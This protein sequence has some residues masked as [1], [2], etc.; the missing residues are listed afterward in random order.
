MAAPAQ[1]GRTQ[2][3]VA[4][5][6]RENQLDVDDARSQAIQALAEFSQRRD[7]YEN[8]RRALIN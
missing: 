3:S 4:G 5:S 2:R 8:A 7:S 6:S 1:W